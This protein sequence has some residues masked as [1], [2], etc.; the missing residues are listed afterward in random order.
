[1]RWNRKPRTFRSPKLFDVVYLDFDNRPYVVTGITI[2][3]DFVGI[4]MKPQKSHA[5]ENHDR[6]MAGGYDQ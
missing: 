1:M 2:T 6:P 4:D 3:P 5:D